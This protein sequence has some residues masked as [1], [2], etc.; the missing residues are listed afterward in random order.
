MKARSNL[1]SAV[2]L[3]AA[4]WLGLGSGTA[5]AQTIYVDPYPAAWSPGPYVVRQT[6]IAPP[7]P[8]VRKR[9][10]VVTRAPYLPAPVYRA[11]LPPYGYIAEV[12]YL[13]PGW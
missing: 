6:V 9:T 8:I 13:A 1:L 2:G 5:S 12:D 4:G 11:P 10:V 7:V 3:A